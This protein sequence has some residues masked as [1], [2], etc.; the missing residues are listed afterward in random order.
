MGEEQI[1]KKPNVPTPP[2][3]DPNKG[4]GGCRG[5]QNSQRWKTNSALGSTGKFKGKTP[6]IE[7]DIF[8]NTGFHDAANFHRS[9]KHIADHLQLTCD[10]E[11]CE[12][13]CTMTPVVITI[14][15][16]PKGIPQ[17]KLSFLVTTSLSTYGKKCTRKP[18]PSWTSTKSTW[19]EPTSS[20]F[21]NAHQVSRMNLK[22]LI[23]SR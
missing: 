15:P 3:G 16:V 14:P 1:D 7:H 6:R 8:D 20:F 23:H 10:N 2:V 18:L 11:V 12:A 5:G 13:I 17:D 19:P 4:R 9:L 22:Q 21:I